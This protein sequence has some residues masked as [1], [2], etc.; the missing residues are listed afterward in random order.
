MV[1]NCLELY[2]FCQVFGKTHDL[3]ASGRCQSMN[4]YELWW[5]F[6]WNQ[7]TTNEWKHKTWDGGSKTCKVLHAVTANS[8]P[9]HHHRWLSRLINSMGRKRGRA[10]LCASRSPLPRRSSSLSSDGCPVRI[11]IS[12]PLFFHSRYSGSLSV[13]LVY[14]YR[15]RSEEN[16]IS[17]IPRLVDR[18]N[19]WMDEWGGS[20]NIGE[21]FAFMGHKTQ[22]L[23][24]FAEFS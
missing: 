24:G 6:S 20:K 15:P 14:R 8:P 22:F 21:R 10:I 19:K 5:V 9:H 13:C 12:I 1:K 16:R 11:L 4:F 17:L 23:E 3:E 2:N 18:M 7:L